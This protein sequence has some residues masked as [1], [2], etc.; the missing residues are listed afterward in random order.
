MPVLV[1]LFL[2][3]MIE[4][5]LYIQVDLFLT[6]NH[7]ILPFIFTSLGNNASKE[8]Q[9][10]NYWLLIDWLPQRM[11]LLLHAVFPLVSHKAQSWRFFCYSFSLSELI[12]S[13][14]NSSADVNQLIFTLLLSDRISACLVDILSKELAKN[15]TQQVQTSV[16][17][18]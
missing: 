7:Q 17:C 4:C 16:H 3:K 10:D 13:S 2:F 6:Q 18:W 11:V 5:A 8:Q 12:S 9:F 14:F 1:T 15:K